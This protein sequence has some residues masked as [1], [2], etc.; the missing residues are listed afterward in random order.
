MRL[1]YYEERTSTN[2]WGWNLLGKLSGFLLA[3]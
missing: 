3:N 1:Q 2:F